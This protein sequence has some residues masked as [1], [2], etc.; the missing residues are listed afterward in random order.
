MLTEVVQ[1]F[2]H[3]ILH[4]WPDRECVQILTHLRDAISSDSRTFI[5]EAILPDHK[6][7]LLYV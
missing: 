4:D 6:S 3:K 5:N 7:P 2:I 1:Y